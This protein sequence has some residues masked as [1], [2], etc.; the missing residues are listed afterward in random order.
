MQLLFLK[1]LENDG[2]KILMSKQD[3]ELL[4]NFGKIED[5]VAEKDLMVAM[6]SDGLV[7]IKLDPEENSTSLG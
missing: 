6:E 7:S 1:R 4:R 2:A 3:R 5:E